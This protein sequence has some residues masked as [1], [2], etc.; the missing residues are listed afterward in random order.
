MTEEMKVAIIGFA[1][2][3]MFNLGP[4]IEQGMLMKAHIKNGTTNYHWVYIKFALF[5]VGTGVAGAM[6][7][8]RILEAAR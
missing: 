6:L 3:T 7:I 1:A 4:C 2:L 8:I 5:L